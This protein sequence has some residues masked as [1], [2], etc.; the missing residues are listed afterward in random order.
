ML[1]SRLFLLFNLG[2]FLKSACYFF[3]RSIFHQIPTLSCLLY[4][5]GRLNNKHYCRRDQTWQR[6]L[7]PEAPATHPPHATKPWF[8]GPSATRTIGETQLSAQPM[9]AF[10]SASFVLCHKKRIKYLSDFLTVSWLCCIC[11][12]N[13]LQCDSGAASVSQS[14]AKPKSWRGPAVVA[15]TRQEREKNK[16]HRPCK[17]KGSGKHKGYFHED[18]EDAHSFH[19]DRGGLGKHEGLS[20]QTAQEQN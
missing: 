8:P 9:P 17:W 16:N 11:A 13:R 4:R 1:L 14:P 20:T 15:S 5:T 3:S 2:E 12:Y 6:P 18:A 10:P 19:S 7:Q